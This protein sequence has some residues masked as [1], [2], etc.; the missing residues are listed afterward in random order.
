MTRLIAALALTLTLALPRPA[1]AAPIPLPDLSRYLEELTLVKADFTQISA[2]GAVVT[3]TLYMRRPGR[4]RFEYD[5]DGGLVVVGGSQVAVFDPVS[6]LP[7]E[8][9]PLKRTPLDLIL[10]RNID[11]SSAAEVLRHSGDAA[12]TSVLLR[13]PETPEAGT[14]E[15][16]FTGNPVELRQWVMTDEAGS[17]TTV[18]LGA[19]ERPRQLSNLLFSI[20]SEIEERGN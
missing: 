13:D 17:A 14:L 15:L 16:V 7:P 3:G 18:V 5:R 9:Y 20:Q 6:N 4:A 19:V 8:Q 1:A 10:S 2:D 12:L 11:L